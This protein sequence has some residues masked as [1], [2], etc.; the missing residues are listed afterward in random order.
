[1]IVRIYKSWVDPIL[2][3]GRLRHP[4]TKMV[5]PQDLWLWNFNNYPI[6]KIAI[7][8]KDKKFCPERGPKVVK[9]AKNDRLDTLILLARDK[10]FLF[11][12]WKFSK[13]GTIGRFCHIFLLNI[14]F[15]FSSFSLVFH[16]FSSEYDNFTSWNKSFCIPWNIKGLFKYYVSH[17]NIKLTIF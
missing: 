2:V 17:I 13:G 4:Q 6:F 11:S 9:L 8:R 1:M 16:W 10:Q 14:T 3:R 7:L 12:P 5:S 15:V